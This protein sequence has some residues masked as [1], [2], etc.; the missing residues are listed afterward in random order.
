MKN[1][2]SSSDIQFFLGVGTS[3][4]DIRKIIW[5]HK[6]F[7]KGKKNGKRAD[8]SGMDLRNC[9]FSEENLS[10][11]NFEDANVFGCNFVDT[12]LTGANLKGIEFTH[13]S[14]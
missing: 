10:G 13:C 11:A 6:G 5:D 8:F 4:D 12:K 9:D 14:R 2:N 7:L 1:S 3:T